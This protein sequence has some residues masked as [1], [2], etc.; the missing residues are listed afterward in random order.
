MLNTHWHYDHTGGNENFGEAGALIFAH[1]NVRTR[2]EK[3]QTMAN[4]RVVEPAPDVALPV[5]TFNDQMSL[6]VNGQT[7]HGLHVEHGHTD[8]DTL[9]HFEEANVIHMGDTFLNG[10][11]PFV[12]LA[13]GGHINGVIEAAAMAL[14]VSDDDTLIIPGHGPLGTRA[15][16]LQF[17]DMLVAIRDR[18]AQRM[19]DGE[20]LETIV[21]ARPTADFDGMVNA[22]GFIKPDMLVTAIYESL[23]Q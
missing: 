3:G 16:L 12:D 20:S 13:S 9:V 21:A 10:G 6:H 5:V 8:G 18:V 1:D 2:M 15:D 19:A 17:H 7:V 4:G 14:A 22:D 11:Y 23:S